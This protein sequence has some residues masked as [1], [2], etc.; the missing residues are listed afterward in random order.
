MEFK[1]MKID[2]LIFPIPSG[3]PC[4]NMVSTKPSLET[5]V[6]DHPF[7]RFHA[8]HC[9]AHSFLHL[10]CIP[11][12]VLDTIVLQLLYNEVL[13]NTGFNVSHTGSSPSS[14]IGNVCDLDQV[15]QP[16]ECQCFH[17]QYEI[18]PTHKATPEDY[19]F[20]GLLVTI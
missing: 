13:R 8:N 18:V 19:M 11:C 1:F 14:P 6:L 16:S 7:S 5:T 4:T 3:W 12:F 15:A 20:I 2:T 10:C 17:R 9:T